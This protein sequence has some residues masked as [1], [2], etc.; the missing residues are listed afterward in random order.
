MKLDLYV[1]PV[2]TTREL[3][4][5]KKWQEE[6]LAPYKVTTTDI[7]LWKVE[8]MLSIWIKPKKGLKRYE[9]RKKQK[10]LRAFN[11]DRN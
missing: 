4:S 5:F 1:G 8:F 2:L 11:V 6:H 9:E 3:F 7:V 10:R